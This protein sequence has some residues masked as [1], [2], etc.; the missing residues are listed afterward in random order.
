MFENNYYQYSH[1]SYD[2]GRFYNNGIGYSLRAM[3]Y[4]INV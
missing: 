1:V 3:V 2:Q 4:G